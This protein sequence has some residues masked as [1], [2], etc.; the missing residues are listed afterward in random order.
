MTVETYKNLGTIRKATKQE[1]D[2][3]GGYFYL[4]KGETREHHVLTL[5]DAR[6]C[7]EWAREDQQKIRDAVTFLQSRGYKIYQEVTWKTL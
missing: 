5:K 7:L 3:E 6:E 4:A 2:G 1:T